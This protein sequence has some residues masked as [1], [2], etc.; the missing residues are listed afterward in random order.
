MTARTTRAAELRFH[1]E[2]HTYTKN[3][4][5]VPNVT[6]A[7]EV[8]DV[9]AGIPQA[10]LERAAAIGQAVHIATELDDRGDLDEASVDDAYWPYL[11]AWR[12]FRAD[13]D[14][15]ANVI[16][17]KVFHPKLWYAGTLDREGPLFGEDALIDVKTVNTLMPSTGPQLAAYLEARNWGRSD[18]IKRRY[19]VQLKEDGTYT[20]KEYRDRCDFGVFQACLTVYNWKANTTNGRTA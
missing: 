13:H 9:Y 10:I 2:N 8:L 15:F 16:E 20:V 4:V 11:D 7:L 19:A 6:R 14:Y 18:K 5:L 12:E 3:G 17:E 1:P